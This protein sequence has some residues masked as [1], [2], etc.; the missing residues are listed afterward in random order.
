MCACYHWL[1]KDSRCSRRVTPLDLLR[2][3]QLPPYDPRTVKLGTY[4]SS[5]SLAQKCCLHV[6]QM[7]MWSMNDAVSLYVGQSGHY[8]AKIVAKYLN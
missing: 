4:V 3:L 2:N 1:G 7:E 6:D 8:L 5:R